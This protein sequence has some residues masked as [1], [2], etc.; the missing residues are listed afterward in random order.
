MNQRT[1][2][3]L[4]LAFLMLGAGYGAAVHSAE[5]PRRRGPR[6]DPG[7]PPGTRIPPAP[8]GVMIGPGWYWYW[9]RDSERDRL[10][11]WL[12]KNT[13]AVFVRKA[14]GSGTGGAAVIILEAVDHV[15]W[16]LPGLPAPAPN[17]IDT[18]IDQIEHSGAPQLSRM[19]RWLEGMRQQTQD[20][21]RYYDQMFQQWLD[22]KLRPRK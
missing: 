8:S 6:V 2:V 11:A 17:G 16:E 5:T 9:L 19:G 18:T 15:A 13:G 20:V 14:M 7:I 4:V 10:A 3:L 22:S 21:V 1:A 12:G